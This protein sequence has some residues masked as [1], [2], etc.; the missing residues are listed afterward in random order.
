[1]GFYGCSG[2]RNPLS[3]LF[4]VLPEFHE[5]FFPD[6]RI[7]ARP[8]Q[9]TM[10]KLVFAITGGTGRRNFRADTAGV[11]PSPATHA[12]SILLKAGVCFRHVWRRHSL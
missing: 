1:M 11:P 8:G 2:H 9:L 4:E 3:V 5:L 6:F 10:V 7:D 12:T